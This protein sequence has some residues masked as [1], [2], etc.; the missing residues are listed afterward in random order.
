MFKAIAEKVGT[1]LTNENWQAAVDEFG[2]IELVGTNIASVCAGKYAAD[3]EFRLVEW[4]SSI[5]ESRRLESA[6]RRAGRE[7]RRLR[8]AEHRRPG[9]IGSGT[10]RRAVERVAL[11]RWIARSSVPRYDA[12]TCGFVAHLVG[13]ALGDHL[14]RLHAVDAV[15][16]RQDHRQVVLDDD[17]RRVELLLDPLDQRTERLGFALRDAGGRLVEADHARR[18]REHRRELDDAAR[19]GRELG[20]EAVGV[21]AETEEVDELGGLARACARSGRIDGEPDERDPERRAV[22]RLEREL[23]RLADGQ[24]GEERRGLE[25]AAEPERGA[26]GARACRSRRGRAARRVPRLGT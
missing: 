4:D 8:V 24:L 15:A 3:D 25:R 9:A 18:D 21:A 7:R 17:E 1:E 23:H 6:H 5:G 10:R 20:D 13:R 26:R 11:L 14:A 2:A 12:M 16:D 22:P 19:A